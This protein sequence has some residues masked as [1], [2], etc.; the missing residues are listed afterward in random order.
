[1]RRAYDIKERILLCFFLTAVFINFLGSIADRDFPF[2]LKT[3]EY[4]Y[5]HKEIPQNDPFSFYGK[6][7]VTDREKFLLTQY[8]IAQVLFYK[9]YSLMGPPGIILLRAGVFSAFIFLLWFTMKKRGFPSAL[10]I[11][12][13]ATILLQAFKADRPQ[14]FSF[15][16]ML[17][18]IL[19]IEKFREKSHSVVPLYFIPPL[20][21]LWANIHGGFVFGIAVILIYALS[22][23]LKLIVNKSNLGYPLEKRRALLFFVTA[24]MTILFSYLNPDFNGQLLATL[25]S[26]TDV[27]WFYKNNREYIS[28]VKEMSVHFGNIVSASIFFIIFGF[29]TIVTFLNAIRTKSIDITVLFLIIFSSTAAFTAVR[30]I[31]FFVAVALPLSMDYRFFADASFLRKFSNSVIS[32]SLLLMFFSFAVVFGLRDYKKIFSIDKIYYPEG[33]ADFLLSN[34]IEA[35][36]FNQSNEGSYFLWRLYPH[37]RVFIDTRLIS[38]EA[39]RDADAISYAIGDYNSPFNLSLAAA[40]SAL[41]PAGLGEISFSSGDDNRNLKNKKPLWEK[42]LEQHNINLIVHEACGQFTKELYPITLRLLRDDKWALIYLDG[43]MLIFVRNIEKNSAI[44]KKFSLPKEL[45]YDEII[46]E[47]VPFVSRRVAISTPYSSLAFAL[48]MKGKYA[49]ARIMIDAALALDK[50]DLTANFCEAYLVLR[51]KEQAKS[52]VSK[53]N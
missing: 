31:P 34:R 23:G 45:I 12:M 14:F 49:E 19:L 53:G 41:V 3:G 24:F 9:I 27:S 47:T 40:L 33:V 20:F 22:E 32:F 26:H 4:I 25:E 6:G 11:A 52:H 18:L 35:N 50:N 37:Y 51:Q 13:L 44:I 42:L 10:I 29:V 7:I 15:L 16:F 8:W 43:S 48:M 17:I 21:L 38:F 30:Y 28:P 5:Q 2:H 39:V 1:M 36:M 46:L